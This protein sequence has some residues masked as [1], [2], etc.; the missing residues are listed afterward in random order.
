MSKNGLYTL[1]KT[2]VS[3]AVLSVVAVLAGLWVVF[4][5]SGGFLA[6]FGAVRGKKEHL[7]ALI[8]QKLYNPKFRLFV[9]I[10]MLPCFQVC[11]KALRVIQSVSV[12]LLLKNTEKIPVQGEAF[13]WSGAGVCCVS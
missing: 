9:Q 3:T 5:G 7:F 4:F 6:V 1:F 2:D 12:F 8:L 13:S 10:T 11:Q